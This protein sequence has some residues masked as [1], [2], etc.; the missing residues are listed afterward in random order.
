VQYSEKYIA[1]SD[2]MNALFQYSADDEISV[3][4]SEWDTQQG[5]GYYEQKYRERVWQYI[6]DTDSF[7]ERIS[8]LASEQVESWKD[9][10]GIIKGHSSYVEDW[11]NYFNGV[12]NIEPES[13]SKDGKSELEKGWSE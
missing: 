13:E 4:L 12:F 6:S 2:F 9:Q 8:D 7:K 1:F 11:Y 5:S 10:I 3:E